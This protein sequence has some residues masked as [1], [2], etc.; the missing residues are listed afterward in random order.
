MKRLSLALALCGLSGAAM[1]RGEF[2]FQFAG[3]GGM[4]TYNPASTPASGAG[5]TI[6]YT[7]S[8]QPYLSGGKAITLPGAKNPITL[9]LKSPI[10]RAAAGAT[11][12]RFAAAMTPIGTILLLADLAGMLAD[13]G[14]TDVKKT[15]TGWSAQKRKSG[16]CD[17][18]LGGVSFCAAGGP[19]AGVDLGYYCLAR[20][21]TVVY[22]NT[23]PPSDTCYEYGIPTGQPSMET[24]NLTEKQLADAIATSSGWPSSKTLEDALA[25]PQVNFETGSRPQVSG[26]PTVEGQPTT[27][28]KTNPDGSTTTTT[29]TP[30][31]SITY[32]GPTVTTTTTTT[33]T[34]TNTAPDGTTT[35]DTTTDTTTNTE[36]EPAPADEPIPGLCELF[37]DILA[38]KKLEEPAPVEI[39]KRDQD[40]TLQSGPSFSGG[41][42]PAD[43]VVSV[44]GQQV[45][46]LSTAQPCDWISAYMKPII[47]LLASIS[48][49]FIVLPRGGD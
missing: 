46:V 48:A 9:A 31:I 25:H 20:T 45:T 8:G 13:Q 18:T 33:T 34:T 29:R 36:P 39:P 37:P 17:A 2:D 42:C 30:T 21:Y 12:A 49:A 40:I 26:A 11:A 28:T 22:G 16:G 3:T 1:A 23:T 47:L 43:V 7:A 4:G 38:C 6:K 10:T 14:M 5:P 44:G 24:V 19:P 41:G 32:T 27:E 35:T 15:A